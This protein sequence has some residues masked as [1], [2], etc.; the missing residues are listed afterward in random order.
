MPNTRCLVYQWCGVVDSLVIQHHVTPRRPKETLSDC[1]SEDEQ[2]AFLT[3][4]GEVVV[5]GTHV[6]VSTR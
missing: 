2:L 3:P 5:A 4:V 1:L 6:V